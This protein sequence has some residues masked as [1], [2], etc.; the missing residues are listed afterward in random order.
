MP[1][2]TERR[3]TARAA[4]SPPPLRIFRPCRINFRQG[5][6]HLRSAV[7]FATHSR[8]PS[9]ATA[10]ESAS[11]TPFSGSSHTP[12]AAGLRDSPPCDQSGP[13][14]I[15]KSGGEHPFGDAA[16]NRPDQLSE[17]QHAAFVKR[18]QHEQRPT[19]AEAS[20]Q[21]TGRRKRRTGRIF[22]VFFHR[23]NRFVSTKTNMRV[24]R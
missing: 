5:L 11:A 21:G 6:S 18:Q 15:T 20:D 7:R 23:L 12:P 9:R 22:F 2:R 3:R 17:A 13:F 1:H 10:A 19:A 14:Q 4:A 16:G 24:S 8:A